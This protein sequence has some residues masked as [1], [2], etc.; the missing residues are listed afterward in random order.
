MLAINEQI[1]IIKKGVLEIINE[2][3]LEQKL[4]KSHRERRPL[5]IK[6]GLDPTAPDIHLGHTVVLRKIRQ[7]QDLGHRA[8]III[9]DF[10]GMIGDP[11]GKS[12][13][14]KQLT[15]EEVLA[16]AKTY[17]QQ[18]CKVLDVNKTEIR[19]N[20]EWLSKLNFADVLELASKCTVARM[21]ERE[22]FKNR[23]A[24]HQ[25]IGIHE[26]LYP[27]MQAFDSV[28]LKA[29]IEIGGTEQRYN[30]LMGRALQKDYKQ[31]IQIA[32][33]L[34]LLL[35]TDGVEKMSKSLNNYIGVD[36]PP[37][38]MYSKTM[39]I[40]DSQIINYFELVTDVHPDEIKLTCEKL[41]DGNINPRDVKMK[42]AL[43]IIAL[44][45]GMEAAKKAEEH[46]V[47][48]FQKGMIPEDLQVLNITAS[49]VVNENVD[50]IKAITMSGIVKSSSEARRLLEQGGV[51]LNGVKVSNWAEIHI[52]NEDV[53]QIGKRGF[54]KIKIE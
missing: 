22:D 18:L 3:E 43:E 34:P 41:E 53:L 11:T 52:N 39:T 47:K 49:G 16:N 50:L 2:E 24:A 36:E 35:G 38:E 46:F 5:V 48:V 28:E 21:L 15:H 20:S 4:I 29:D 12:K 33:F 42:L 31:D 8:V 51:K 25:S 13:G 14:R 26:F 1:K 6:L 23:F 10:T 37:Q 44:Y 27:L 54:V 9:G 30:I 7:L 19:F 40:P 32:L 45:H 17:E